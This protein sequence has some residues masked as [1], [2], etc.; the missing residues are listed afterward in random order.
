MIPKKKF[1]SDGQVKTL[2]LRRAYVVDLIV[3]LSEEHRNEQWFSFRIWLNRRGIISVTEM[4]Q[5]TI[6][7]DVNE[8]ERDESIKNSLG[9]YIHRIVPNPGWVNANHKSA[10]PWRLF[11]T[12]VPSLMS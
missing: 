10:K 1:I 7:E 2:K 6:P 11:V 9:E 5:D 4:N 12:T 8:E 3:K